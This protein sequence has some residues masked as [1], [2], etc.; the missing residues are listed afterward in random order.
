MAMVLSRFLYPTLMIVKDILSFI[1]HDSL[2]DFDVR[3]S[4]R[5]IA[6]EA[7]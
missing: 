1:H 4:T 7:G 6:Q 3:S 2:I 5:D